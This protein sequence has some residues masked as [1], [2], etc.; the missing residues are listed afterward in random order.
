MDFNQ[1][2]SKD[3]TLQFS[4]SEETNNQE[5]DLFVFNHLDPHH[6][7]TSLWSCVRKNYGWLPIR[8]I[9]RQNGKIVAGAQILEYRLL[10]FIK[11]GY[12]PRGPLLS[13][14]LDEAVFIECLKQVAKNR[15]LAYLAISLPYYAHSLAQSFEKNGIMIRPERIPPTIWAKATVVIDLNMD[16]EVIFSKI[17]ASKRREIR[18]GQ[19]DGIKVRMGQ[20]EDIPIVYDLLLAICRRREVK[21]NIPDQKFIELLWENFSSEGRIKILIAEKDGEPVSASVLM[22][23]GGWVRAWRRG[24]S[25]LY[26]K[27]QP[28]AVLFWEAICWAKHN[29][30]KYFDFVGI[31]LEDAK[32]ISSGRNHSSPFISKLTFFKVSFGGDIMFLPGEYCYFNSRFLAFFARMIGPWLINNNMFSRITTS[33]YKKTFKSK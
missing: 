33:L 23:T 16:L 11:I 29:G 10:P 14:E 25:G 26:A 20:K 1:S 12:L 6:E 2:F 7:Q 31:D 3:K 13:N 19:R 21:C 5:W 15:H 27:K 22:I 28:N 30:Y 24:W 17:W 32:A 9:I 8:L 18:I 4:I